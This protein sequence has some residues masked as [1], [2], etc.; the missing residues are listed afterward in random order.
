MPY[1]SIGDLPDSV[2]KTL[3]EKAQ[4]IFLAAYNSAWDEYSELSDKKSD[5]S[6]EET[7]FKV[8][9]AAVK[10]KYEKKG[11]SWQKKG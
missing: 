2:T 7:A 11:D 9:W 10:Q 5:A 4:K 8:A 3:P 6:R 1:E